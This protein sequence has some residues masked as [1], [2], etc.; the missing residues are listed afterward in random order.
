MLFVVNRPAQGDHHRVRLE[1][2]WIGILAAVCLS[3]HLPDVAGILAALAA[4]LIVKKIVSRLGLI[5]LVVFVFWLKFV[6][7][8]ATEAVVNYKAQTGE[9]FVSCVVRARRLNE[10]EKACGAPR[11]AAKRIRVAQPAPFPSALVF[12]LL[13]LNNLY[14]EPRNSI[15]SHAKR[16]AFA[17]SAAACFF[18]AKANRGV[19]LQT[20]ELQRLG[21]LAACS[22][23][24]S[25]NRWHFSTL[26]STSIALAFSHF[27][28]SLL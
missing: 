3:D 26:L 28:L 20:K 2:A 19:S 8:I 9:D 7:A 12:E 10:S 22:I 16:H 1:V 13:A 4:Y 17:F 5:S 15:K 21:I 24:P 11:E 23:L 27:V 25:K 14:T 6:A 18:V